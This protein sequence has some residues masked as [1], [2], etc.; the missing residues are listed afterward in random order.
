MFGLFGGAG[1]NQGNLAGRR[2]LTGRL[3]RT[4]D[5]TEGLAG[6]RRGSVACRCCYAETY[7]DPE[8]PQNN[9]EQGEAWFAFSWGEGVGE[10]SL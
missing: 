6:T 3:A 9:W 10:W 4:R 5:L 2:D 1:A 8:D 7:P